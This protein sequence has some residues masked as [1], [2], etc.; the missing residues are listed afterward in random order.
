MY[1]C[2]RLTARPT[3]NK[4][5]RATHRLEDNKGAPAAANAANV[6]QGGAGHTQAGRSARPTY[7][8]EAR[9]THR[10]GRTP[11]R[12]T[13][14]DARDHART[15]VRAYEAFV[16]HTMRGITLGARTRGG[17]LDERNHFGRTHLRGTGTSGKHDV[18]VEGCWTKLW[19]DVRTHEGQGHQGHPGSTTCTWRDAE[20]TDDD[21]GAQK[22]ARGRDAGRTRRM[23]R[24]CDWTELDIRAS[25]RQ[26]RGELR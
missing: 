22:H 3:Y 15:H 20:R 6:Q 25:Q 21:A 23:T 26:T 17:M 9:A 12:R 4:E 11:L 14:Y 8:K 5:A 10:L 1:L 16:R 13:T 18:H 7:N 19:T 24:R 2:G